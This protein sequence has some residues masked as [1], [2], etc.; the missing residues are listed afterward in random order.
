[1]LSARQDHGELTAHAQR[2]R[3]HRMAAA[4]SGP[5][6]SPC[7]RC[8]VGRVGAASC[9]RALPCGSHWGPLKVTAQSPR[10]GRGLLEPYAETLHQALP[11]CSHHAGLTWRGSC[12][13]Q[14]V[15]SEGGW[16]AFAWPWGSLLVRVHR[17]EGVDGWHGLVSSGLGPSSWHSPFSTSSSAGAGAAR[18][19]SL[20]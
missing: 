14:T 15:L 4:G 18:W 11:L 13:L 7:H 8:Q 2:T 16:W 19:L 3:A 1:M 9:V 20:A 12:S 17:A 10:H 6:G 5:D